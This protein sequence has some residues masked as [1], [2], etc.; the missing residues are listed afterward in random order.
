MI[1][2]L[3]NQNIYPSLYYIACLLAGQDYDVVFLS[4][5]K[6]NIH[7]KGNVL[8]EPKWLELKQPS[9][10]E[11]KFPFVRGNYHRVFKAVIQQK[12]D[13]FIGQHQLALLG[14]LYSVFSKKTK[15][16]SYFCDHIVNSWFTPLMRYFANRFDAYID[17]CDLRLSWR[18]S[19]WIKLKC[20]TFIIRQ[21]IPFDEEK[22]F[23]PHN[24]NPKII[25]TGSDLGKHMQWELLSRF[26]N[27][28]IEL[29][30]EFHWYLPGTSEKR[31][32]AQLISDSKNYCVF[33]PVAKKELLELLPKYDAG[34]LWA[35][36]ES[37]NTIKPKDTIVFSML[38]AASNKICEYHAAGLL[39]IH[40]GNPGL[41]Y[42]PQ[43][44][45][46][47]INPWEPEQSAVRLASFLKQTE[48]LENSRKAAFNYYL[49]TM[50]VEKQTETFVKFL[51]EHSVKCA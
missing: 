29:G 17:I 19:E 40:T 33:E 14:V 13:I 3:N 16:I 18:K 2:A 51:A 44:V 24:Q 49:N 48:L 47:S 6:P 9:V 5:I 10:L 7:L 41:T 11:N 8:K 32:K 22:K 50:N 35:P 28:L 4:R 43:E 37:I 21:A 30:I 20:P 45:G 42:L 31:I 15:V 38:S 26:I 27:T 34:L 39:T 46:Y 25:F 12:P 36:V 1:A 23:E